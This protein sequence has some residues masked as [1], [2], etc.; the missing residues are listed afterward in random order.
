VLLLEK[1]P[2]GELHAEAGRGEDESGPTFL[3]VTAHKGRVG[4]GTDE[5]FIHT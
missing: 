5:D 2:L 1:L 4:G 3:V